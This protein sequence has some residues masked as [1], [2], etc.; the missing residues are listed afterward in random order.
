MCHIIVIKCS[1]NTLHYITLYGN[2]EYI[3]RRVHIYYI[4]NFS[5]IL[6]SKI[7]GID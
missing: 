7:D 4:R 2:L 6:G 3:A 1:N 5:F